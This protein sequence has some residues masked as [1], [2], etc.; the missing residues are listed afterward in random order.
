MRQNRVDIMRQKYWTRLSRVFVVF[1]V[2]SIV[3]FMPGIVSAS[4]VASQQSCT[5]NYGVSQTHFGSGGA[6]CD[7][8]S[9]S[10][11]PHSTNYCAGESAGDLTDGNSVGSSYQ[12]RSGSGLVVNRQPYIQMTVGGVAT[13]LGTLTPSTTATFNAN[14]TVKTYLAGSYIV[15]VAAKPPTNNGPG[16]HTIATPGTPSVPTAGTEMFGMNLTRNSSNPS[17][18]PVPYGA[19]PQCSP[20][21]TF[22]PSGAMT[23]AVTSNY[24]QDGKYYYPGSGTNYTD[25]IVSSNTSTGSVSYTLSYV[26]DISNITPTGLYSYNGIFV[27]TSTY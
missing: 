7:P 3:S 20:D 1:A 23:S 24:N 19:Y 6:I 16:P 14:F 11:S 9:L 10:T 2:V 17:G 4:C 21:A 15:Q 5:S 27:A 26:Y 8:N 12:L 18:G 13:D 22:C 25:T